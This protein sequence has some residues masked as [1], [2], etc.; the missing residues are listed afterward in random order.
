MQVK[1]ILDKLRSLEEADGKKSEWEPDPTS[2]DGAG[3]DK[4]NPLAGMHANDDAG[5]F[6]NSSSTGNASD[7]A[8]AAATKAIEK[9]DSKTGQEVQTALSTPTDSNPEIQTLVKALDDIDKFLKKYGV[10]VETIAESIYHYYRTNINDFLTPQQQMKNWAILAE[11]NGKQKLDEFI[12]APLAARMASRSMARQLARRMAARQARQMAARNASRMASRNAA[13]NMAARN[14]ASHADLDMVTGAKKPWWRTGLGMA[15]IVGGG[16]MMAPVIKDV[17]KGLKG[18]FGGEQDQPQMT[19]QTGPEEDPNKKD[20]N[21][22]NTPDVNKPQDP[23]APQTPP[24]GNTSDSPITSIPTDEVQSFMKNMDIVQKFAKDQS[25]IDALPETIK[26]R[27][28][29]TIKAVTEF[30]EKAPS[31]QQ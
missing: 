10:K 15:S 18:M 17:W 28:T 7:A 29:N 19:P 12:F 25:K 16:I 27:L 2:L 5:G 24:T 22:P 26:I 20:P 1:D 9:P 30:M 4:P 31:K 3:G 14:A 6:S 23:N 8:T 21:D 13:R 11:E